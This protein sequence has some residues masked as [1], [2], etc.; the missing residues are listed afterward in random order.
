MSTSTLPAPATLSVPETSPPPVAW[1]SYAAAEWIKFRTVRSST[2]T[3]VVAFVL[4]VGVGGL[5]CNRMAAHL[6]GLTASG[7]ADY[8]QGIDLTSQSLIGNAIAQ[9]AIGLL[10]VLVVTS[11]YGTGMIRASVMAMPRRQHWLAAKL[12]VFTGVALVAGQLLTFTSFWVGQAFLATQHSGVSIV[13]PG[14]L[15]SVVATG[16]Y[17]TL[18]GIIG[19]ALGLIVKHTAGALTTLVGILFLLPAIDAAFPEP[20][21]GQIA[22]FLPENIAEQCATVMRVSERFPLWG[23]LALVAGYA[24]ILLIVGAVLLQRRDA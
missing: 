8:L 3:M 24:A 7:R 1:R 11:E 21:Q 4:A 10:G 9:L 19:A 5:T 14:V 12:A 18:I 16:L 6:A 22:R 17:V 2:V 20:L 13:D 15:R 23:G